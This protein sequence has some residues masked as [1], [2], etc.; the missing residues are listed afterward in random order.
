VSESDYHDAHSDLDP[1][2]LEDL[3]ME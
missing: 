1:Y 2:D 3:E